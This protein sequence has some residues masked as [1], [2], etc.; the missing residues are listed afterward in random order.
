MLTLLDRKLGFGRLARALTIG[1]VLLGAAF[2]A[3]CGDDGD[4]QAEVVDEPQPNRCRGD[5]HTCPAAD[6]GGGDRQL[7]G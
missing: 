7:C 1:L 5:H 2:L 6:P 3:A 4:T